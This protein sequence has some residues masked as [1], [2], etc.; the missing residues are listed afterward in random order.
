[1]LLSVI[2][3]S[4]NVTNNLIAR[5]ITNIANT[6]DANVNNSNIKILRGRSGGH[7]RKYWHGLV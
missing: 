1:M 4:V 5:I 7:T 3:Y 2:Y 6:D